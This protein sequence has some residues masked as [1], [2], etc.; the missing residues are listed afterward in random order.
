MLGDFL[1]KLVTAPIKIIAMPIRV[2]ADIVED[3]GDNFIEAVTDSVEKQVKD[4][5]E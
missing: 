3:D 1:G 4:I 2:L 5:V